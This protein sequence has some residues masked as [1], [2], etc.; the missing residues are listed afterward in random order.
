MTSFSTP[1][2]TTKI[3]PVDECGRRLRCAIIC[4]LSARSVSAT[5]SG[6]LSAGPQGPRGRPVPRTKRNMRLSRHR[7]ANPGMHGSGPNAGG[8]LQ[9]AVE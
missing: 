7:A 3:D 8:Q 2:S 5:R 1:Y 6:H 4:R 9:E